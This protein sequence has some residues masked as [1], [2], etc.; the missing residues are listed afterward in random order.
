MSS[1][2][3]HIFEFDRPVCQTWERSRKDCGGA[4]PCAVSDLKGFAARQMGDISVWQDAGADTPSGQA[5]DLTLLE[6]GLWMGFG[7]ECRNTTPCAHV[8]CMQRRDELESLCDCQQFR[9]LQYFEARESAAEWS[10]R[11]EGLRG[12]PHRMPSA[13]T[14]IVGDEAQLE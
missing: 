5:S 14:L 7:A 9:N 4:G 1:S 13:G 3:V 12:T 6:F 11:R 2:V 10:E 8:E